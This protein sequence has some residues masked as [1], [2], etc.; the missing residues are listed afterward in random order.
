[1][2][3]LLIFVL[4]AL[5]IVYAY[6]WYVRGI[7]L[8]LA[9]EDQV[10]LPP[11]TKFAV[12][13]P[14]PDIPQGDV[15]PVWTSAQ[16]MPSA[17][18]DVAAAAIG[19]MI[20]VVGGID[21]FA[22]S[23]STVEVFDMSKNVWSTAADLP[24]QLHH[25]ALVEFD[26]FLYA[27]GGL[28]GLSMTPSSSVYRFDPEKG[29][30]R[31][32]KPMLTAVGAAAAIVHKGNIHV[33]GGQTAAGVS[34]TYMIYDPK[35]E[36]WSWGEGL[37][38]PRAHHGAASLGDFIAVFGGRA[39]SL[40]HNVR[41]TDVLID[42]SDEWERWQPMSIKRSGFGTVRLGGK[43]YAIGG[44]APT[45]TMDRVERLDPEKKVWELMPPMPTAR[46]GVGAAAAG[47]RI[48]VIG[49]GKHPGISVSDI[50]EVLLPAGYADV[51]VS[52]E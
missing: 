51:E 26:G 13:I 15:G 33:L 43:A 14:S 31:D 22:R 24:G 4:V 28:Q 16:S 44:E 46:Q 52:G 37:L 11:Y 2:K 41:T 9:E 18:T 50:N 29:S 32:M 47:G 25:V 3:K 12:R 17:R 1:M 34:D 38:S 35:T 6:F 40:A 42:G 7:N 19:D 36:E 30:W 27:L 45:T 49:G 10:Y 48:F 39:S 21:S 8:L 5:A 20:Y 23:V